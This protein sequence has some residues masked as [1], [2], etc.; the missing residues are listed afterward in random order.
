[1]KLKPLFT[2]LFAAGLLTHALVASAASDGGM[3][4]IGLGAGTSAYGIN[5]SGQVVGQSTAGAFLWSNGIMT[6]LGPP[7]S[8]AYAVNS[9]GQV[10]GESTYGVVWSNGSAIDLNALSG[11]HNFA[12][13]IDDKGQVVGS[14]FPELTTFDSHAALWSNGSVANLGSLG[15]TL[16]VARGINDNGQVVGY[17]E[18]ANSAATHAFRWSNGAMT[19]LGT[20]GGSNSYAWGIN[21]NGQVAGYSQVAGNS[22]MHAFVWSYGSMTDLG[23][24]GGSGSF[25]ESINDSGQAVGYSNTVGT[26]DSHAFLWSA[27]RMFDLNSLAPTGWNLVEARAIN[28]F[29]QIAGYG[30]YNGIAEGFMITIHP[31]WQG[32][33]GYWSDTSRWNYGGMGSFGFNPGAP[34][35]VVI[36]PAGS[37]TIRGGYDTKVRSL[38][39]A[40]NSGEIVTLNLSSGSTTTTNGTTIGANGVL[41]GNGRLGGALAV[42]SGGLVKVVGGETMQVT[43]GALANNGR[44]SVLGTAANPASME[45][46]GAASNNTTGQINLQNANVAFNGGLGN[47]GQINVTFGTSNISGAVNNLAGGKIIVANGAS[48]SFYDTVVNNGEL[49]VS[50]GGAANFFSLVSGAGS[51]TGGG[52]ARFEGGFHAGN[53]PALVT[54][55]FESTFSSTSP[56]EMELGGTTPG[57]CNT[58]ADKIIFNNKVTLEGGDLNVLWWNGHTAQAGD[59]YDLFDWN[60]PL[61]GTFGHV[62]LPTLATGLAWHSENLYTTGELS[63]AAVPEPETY[64]MLLAGLGMIGVVTRRRMSRR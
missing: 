44:I 11:G 16:G 40:G 42:Q 55:A 27:G 58:C 56:I 21:N 3:S 4:I 63:V 26:T 22:A 35:D 28:S 33:D 24:L 39:I 18:L 13:A 45:A 20:L 36:N 59:V 43:G 31:D 37:A 7:G 34:H 2:N 41:A 51:F 25:A 57:N 32:G 52:Q 47:S 48:A 30:T 38:A 23:T 61:T 10:V 62:Y 15:G 5:D 54:I 29:A 8:V 9:Q 60:A 49:R 17:S 19:D 50:A 1:M 12:Y 64:A 14:R 46:A 53:S 6:N